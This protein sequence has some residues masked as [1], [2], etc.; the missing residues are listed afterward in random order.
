MPITREERERILRSL[1]TVGPDKAIGYLPRNTI[2]AILGA[3]QSLSANI[4]KPCLTDSVDSVCSRTDTKR[5]RN[6]WWEAAKVDIRAP[7]LRPTHSRPTSRP[8]YRCVS[9]CIGGSITFPGHAVS[10][11]E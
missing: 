8:D 4:L 9:V 2:A 10:G 11:T 5:Y 3:S 7:E 6:G 1:R